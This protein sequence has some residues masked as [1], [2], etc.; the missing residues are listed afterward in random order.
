MDRDVSKVAI[1]QFID[2]SG[3]HHFSGYIYSMNDNRMLDFYIP[4]RKLNLHFRIHHQDLDSLLEYKIE[5]GKIKVIHRDS[6]QTIII[7]QHQL[8]EL[9]IFVCPQ[10]DN[11]YRD[12]T[13]RL[14]ILQDLI[15]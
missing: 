10:K 8:I 14:G 1:S 13:F 3:Q 2:Q 7:P 15:N 12:L 9:E 5:D 4:G 11:P 6:K